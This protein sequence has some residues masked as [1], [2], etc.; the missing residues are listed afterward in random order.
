LI[1]TAA[2]NTSHQ[3]RAVRGKIP[4]GV[5]GG[6]KARVRSVIGALTG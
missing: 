5:E 2:G 3:D 4:Q 1:Y 6:E